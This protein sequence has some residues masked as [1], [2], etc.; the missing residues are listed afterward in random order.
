MQT[1]LVVDNRICG[2]YVPGDGL[3]VTEERLNT[4]SAV[5]LLATAENYEQEWESLVKH[6]SEDEEVNADASEEALPGYA[7][8]AWAVHDWNGELSPW[9]APAVFGKEGFAGHGE[10]TLNWMDKHLMPKVKEWFGKKPLILCGYSLAGLFSLWALTQRDDYNGA[11]SCSGSLWY[12][13]WTEYWKNMSEQP[14]CFEEWY[15]YLSLGK[16]EEKTRNTRMASVGDATRTMAAELEQDA[17]VVI[18]TLEWNEGGHFADSG[19]RLA[20]GIRWIL[21]NQHL[22][23]EAES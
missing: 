15:V 23:T 7:V 8:V 11:V 10:D 14:G 2:V 16:K 19:E 9:P 21:D 5:F 17:R 1:E 20:K 13:G 3:N 6:L 12:D 22:I 4:V 18:S